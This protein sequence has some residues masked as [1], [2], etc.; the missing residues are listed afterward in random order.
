MTFELPCE[1][2]GKYFLPA[3][4]AELVK[5]LVNEKKMAR[6]DVCRTLDLTPAAVTNYFKDARGKNFA[7]PPKIKREIHKFGDKILDQDLNEASIVSQTCTVCTTMRS[8]EVLC[9]MHAKNDARFKGCT[10]CLK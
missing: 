1:M 10:A 6:K 8:L 7:L 4:R 5:Y 2:I 9:K 3:F